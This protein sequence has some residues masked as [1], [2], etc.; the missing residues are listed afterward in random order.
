MFFSKWKILKYELTIPNKVLFQTL[1]DGLK[2]KPFLHGFDGNASK[3]WTLH[4][5]IELPNL[6]LDL[7]YYISSQVET[8]Y[9][10]NIV[11][12]LP[13]SY[14]NLSQTDLLQDINVQFIIGNL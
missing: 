11:N 12:C 10:S 1:H 6:L 5:W 7:W 9:W 4:K 13:T 3:W 8:F 2:G 14:I